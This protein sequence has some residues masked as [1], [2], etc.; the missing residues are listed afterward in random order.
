D[1]HTGEFRGTF[2]ADAALGGFVY[3]TFGPD[4][5]LYAGEFNASHNIRRYDGSTGR[6]LGIFATAAGGLV[7]PTGLAYAPHGKLYV[8]SINSHKIVRYNGNTGAFMDVFVPAHSGGL[9]GPDTLSFGPDG[10]LYV[11]SQSPNAVLRFNGATG[12]FM[13]AF[14]AGSGLGLPRGLL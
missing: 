1:A 14:V 8:A 11:A 7:S 13:D 9:N 2:V 6:F 3:F 10:N 5:N 12:A 4:G